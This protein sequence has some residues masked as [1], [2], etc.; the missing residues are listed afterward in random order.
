MGS[1]LY[2]R[3]MSCGN[4][5]DWRCMKK[6]RLMTQDISNLIRQKMI[7]ATFCSSRPATYKASVVTTT[8]TFNDALSTL[9]IWSFAVSR[10]KLGYT[11]LI[12][13]GRDFL[14]CTRLQDQGHIAYS[15]LMARRS[16]TPRILSIYAVFILSQPR[17]LR[18]AT[19]NL[20]WPAQGIDHPM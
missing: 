17:H 19:Y 15:T 5:L 1:K 13:N 12:R 11:I 14:L 8:G 16:Q 6:A 7:D 18:M 4:L 20:S 3:L 10:T 2:Y 9:E